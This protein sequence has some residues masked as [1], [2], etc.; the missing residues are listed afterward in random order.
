MEREDFLAIIERLVDERCQGDAS[1][2]G[3]SDFDGMLPF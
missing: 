3:L 2:L 1:Q